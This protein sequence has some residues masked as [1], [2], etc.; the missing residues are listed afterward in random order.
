MTASSLPAPPIGR[1]PAADPFGGPKTGLAP[2]L[3]LSGRPWG[4]RRA[5][6]GDD[7]LRVAEHV[8]SG[9]PEEPEAGGDQP[10]LTAVVLDQGCSVRAPVELDDQLGGDIK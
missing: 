8:R 1:A 4:E 7:A 10:V 5:D 6:L 2:A 3:E 9:E